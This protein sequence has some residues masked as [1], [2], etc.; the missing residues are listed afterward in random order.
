MMVLIGFVEKQNEAD[1]AV[2]LNVLEPA[3]LKQARL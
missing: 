1:E 2:W 3:D